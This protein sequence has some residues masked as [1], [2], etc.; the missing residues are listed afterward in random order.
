[1]N[2]QELLNSGQTINITVGLSDLQTFANELIQSTKRELEEAVISDKTETYA[3][4]EQVC[5]IL[6]V[7]QST[8]WRWAQREYLVPIEIG[9]KRKYK[10]SSVKAILNGGRKNV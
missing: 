6:S 10:M 2:L 9:G 1:M 5:E 7:N 8:L 3:T 4:R